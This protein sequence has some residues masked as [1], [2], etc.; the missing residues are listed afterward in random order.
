MSGNARRNDV[1]LPNQKDLRDNLEDL[2]LLLN[3]LDEFRA[4]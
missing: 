4:L 3:A 1:E 2:D